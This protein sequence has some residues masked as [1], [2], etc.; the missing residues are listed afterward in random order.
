[1][2]ER[3]SLSSSSSSSSFDAIINSLTSASCAELEAGDAEKQ[4]VPHSSPFRFTK[5]DRL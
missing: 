5:E 3:R 4:H 2:Q 1:M